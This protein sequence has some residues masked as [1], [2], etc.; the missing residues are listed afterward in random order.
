MLRFVRK[1]G[2]LALVALGFQSA[3]G[4][5]LLGPPNQDWQTPEIAYNLGGDIGTPHNL[6]EE[7]RWN[8]PF[9]Y[10]AFDQNFLDY[11]GSN[12]VFAVEQAIAI[13]NG[14]TNF[15]QYTADLTEVPLEA[16]RINYRAQALHLLDL[17]SVALNLTLEE[18]GLTE[19]DRY[20][21][22][23]RT[24]DTQPGLS[25]PWMY[26][27]VIKLSFDPVNWQPTSY[28]NGTLYTYL[29]QE[30][31]SGGPPLAWTFNYPVDPLAV[32]HLP[33]TSIRTIDYGVYM[34]GLTR[35]D[36]GGLRYSYRTNNI[37][38]EAMS[39]D[40]VMFYTNVAGGQQLLWTSN[41]TLL[42]SQA[43][44]NNAAALQTLYPDL[45]IV[46]T[47]NIFTNI[48]VTNLTAYFTN[49]PWDPIGM[50]PH[51]AFITNRTLTVQ[52]WYRH[53]FANVVT[54]QFFNGA[55][56]TVSVPDVTV[57]TGPAL[58]TVLTTSVTNSPFMPVGSPPITNTTSFT[59]AT[60]D[61]VGEFFILPTNL[62]GVV[63]SGVQATFVSSY[64]NEVV[65]ATN[66]PPG[67]TNTQFYT[68][69]VV[70]YSTNHAFTYFPVDC[71]TTNVTLRQGINKFTFR[72]ANYDSLVGR[73]F[74]PITNVYYLIEVTNG[75]PVTRW[76]QRVITQPD[77][78]YSAQDLVTPG[79]AAVRTVTAGNFNDANANANLAGPG[80]IEPN[81]QI[82]FNKIGPW[83]INWYG[84]NFILDGLSESTAST[85]FI[86][87]SF[88][89]STNDPVVYPSGTS[90]ASLEAQILFQI[91]TAA[92]PDGKVGIAYPPTQLQ[93]SGGQPPFAWSLASGSP[94]LPPGLRLSATGTISG[95][96]T[97]RGTYGI[98][99]SAMGGDARA[100]ARSL[101]IIINP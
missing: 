99:V 59:Y 13:L 3:S 88:D 97:A 32:E 6:G 63:I 72:R 64:T 74:Q 98:T 5:S 101:S 80:N 54:F 71:V 12:G 75:L 41:L 39:S 42:A 89:G 69:S 40:S 22:T 84:T 67:F 76:F 7:Y 94:A 19:S 28:I 48:W 81:M 31:C 11:F 2:G 78:L 60:N 68:R 15:S 36:V 50:P 9:I 65:S 100:T 79:G 61:V 29:I 96:P 91:I 62:C 70:N 56:T 92:L 73:F 51:L 46:S 25:C 43:L 8:T 33:A 38:W 30:I 53:I 18:L 49:G 23:L 34:T 90:I 47:T 83:L 55:W 35:D 86:W 14:L 20:V 82:G 77:F 17:K 4:F 93:A 66:A 26:Y 44:T 16:R 21:W 27:S 85:N 57:R 52:N 10:Y 45:N 58:Y 37:N 95:T 24:R 87:G 1:I